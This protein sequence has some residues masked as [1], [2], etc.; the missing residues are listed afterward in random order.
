MR[1]ISLFSHF[2]RDRNEKQFPSLC[3]FHGGPP[4]SVSLKGE[5]RDAALGDQRLT[6]RL[7]KVIEELGAKPEHERARRHARQSRNGSRLSLL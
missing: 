5:V 7:G 6:K 1:M 3:F 4:M 2:S